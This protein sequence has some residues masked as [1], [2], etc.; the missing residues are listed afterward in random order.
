MGFVLVIFIKIWFLQ[1]DGRAWKPGSLL[2]TLS[3]TNFKLVWK[4]DSRNVCVVD[5]LTGMIW[6]VSIV[7]FLN[8]THCYNLEYLIIV[9]TNVTHMYNLECF[10]DLLCSES[11]CMSVFLTVPL[12]KEHT[13]KYQNYKFEGNHRIAC[14]LIDFH[15]VVFVYN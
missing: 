2:A 7:H 3:F 4:V 15:S 10:N 8:V 9:W 6:N 12:C 14:V 1:I 11:C 13:M 5:F